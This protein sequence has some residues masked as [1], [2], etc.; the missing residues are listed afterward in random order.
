MLETE[1]YF[2]IRLPDTQHTLVGRID[3]LIEDANGKLVAF[4]TKTENRNSKRNLPQ[5]WLAKSQASLYVWAASEIY[6]KP[7]DSVL[8][9]ICTRGSDKGQ[10]GPAFRRDLLHRSPQQI[11]DAIS[12]VIW[13]ADAAEAL[14]GEMQDLSV[15]ANKRRARFPQNTESCVNERGY[16]C[17]LYAKCHMGSEE[18]L[19]TI[20]PYAYLG[21]K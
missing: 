11:S 7:I 15:D 17:D 12:D 1:K 2:E 19:V 20:S 21:I 16:Q 6:K 10:V 3:M 4:E 13:M 5:A 18:G 8:L 9:N 14:Q